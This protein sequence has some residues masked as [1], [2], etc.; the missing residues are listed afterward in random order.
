MRVLIAYG[1]SHGHT[2]R[3]AARIAARLQQLGHDVTVTDRLL[4][5]RA[6]AFDAVIVGA[7]VHGTRYPWRISR[8]I[9][10]NRRAL[11]ALPSAFFS[12]SLL[13]LSRKSRQANATLALPRRAT[14]RL[15][16]TPDLTEVF[17]GALRWKEQYGK[18]K[19]LGVWMWRLSLGP[20]IDSR[21][22]EQ[23]FTDWQAVDRFTDTFCERM[24]LMAQAI[25]MQSHAQA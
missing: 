20:M 9:R 23:V 16:W 22:S 17:G 6:A 11:E 14:A 5:T 13:Q 2:A 12:V 3:I 25:A 7:R 24:G 10:R 18:L 15:G 4:R 19:P 8:F 1:S 21:L